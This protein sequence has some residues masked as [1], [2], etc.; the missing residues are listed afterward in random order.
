MWN[1][2]RVRLASRDAAIRDRT[3]FPG[4]RGRI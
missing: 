4:T 2:T 1:W 3:P